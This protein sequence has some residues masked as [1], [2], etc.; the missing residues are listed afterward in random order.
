MAPGA[1]LRDGKA[2]DGLGRA[3]APSPQDDPMST[4]GLDA[5]LRAGTV[6]VEDLVEILSR[7]TMSW[8]FSESSPG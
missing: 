4:F 8:S 7:R 5:S 2:A 3:P 6:S 1:P